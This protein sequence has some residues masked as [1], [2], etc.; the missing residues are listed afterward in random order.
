M[1]VGE[2][3]ILKGAACV[4]VKEKDAVCVIVPLVPVTLRVVIPIGV[5]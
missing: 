2:T 4:T 1:E 5:V 3:W